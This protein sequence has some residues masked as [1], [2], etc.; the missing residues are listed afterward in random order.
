[1]GVSAERGPAQAERGDCPTIVSYFI[2]M[3]PDE[4]G[5]SFFF[6]IRVFLSDCRR[7][8]R[9][10]L[11]N[12]GSGLDAQQRSRHLRS[13]RIV[14]ARILSSRPPPSPQAFQR[15]LS[16]LLWF[17]LVGCL[18]PIPFY[19]LAR[20]FPLSFYRYIN[21]PVFFAGLGPMPPAYGITYISWVCGF[22]FNFVVRRFHF[23]WLWLMRYNY[24]AALDS[25]LALSMITIFFALGLF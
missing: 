6:W 16:G 4:Y 5:S 14:P 25:E 8:C 19:F 15:H 7:C 13:N 10:N 11:C 1:M 21:V 3:V 24:P 17:S 23:R 22:I 12:I 20:R 18:A 2:V 9:L